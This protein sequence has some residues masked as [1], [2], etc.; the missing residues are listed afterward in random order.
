MNQ[1]RPD[2]SGRWPVHDRR[3]MMAPRTTYTATCWREGTAW[4][5]LIVQ[6]DRST[7]AA[8]LSDVD[9][10]A[11]RMIA[12]VTDV[13]PELV[14]VVVDLRVPEGSARLLDAATAARQEADVVS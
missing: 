8:R 6:L 13:D 14:E 4:T 11:R 2:G 10:A 5:V 1:R 9:T 7:R 3:S 12:A